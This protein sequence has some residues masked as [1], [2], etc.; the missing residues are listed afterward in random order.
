MNYNQNQTLNNMRDYWQ[1]QKIK[2]AIYPKFKIQKI[3][4]KFKTEA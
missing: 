3:N 1:N 4:D 2:S